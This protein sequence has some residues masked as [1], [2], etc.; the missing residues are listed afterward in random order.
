MNR[1]PALADSLFRD[2]ALSRNALLLAGLVGTIAVTLIGLRH[3]RAFWLLLLFVPL[4]VVA[5]ID[6][7]Q[8][9][10]SLRRNY[11]VSARFRWFFEWLRPFLRSYIVESDLDGRPFSHDERALVYA[12]AKGDVSTHPF[13][14]EL[15]VYSEEYEW[16]AHS[17][18]PSRHAEKYTRVSV[19]TDQCSRP[20]SAARLNISAMSFGALGSNAI[21]A[22]N[23]GARIGGFYHDTGEGGLS[24]YHLKHGGDVV[25]ELGSGYFGC[26]DA[27]GNFDPAHFRDKATNDAVV[28]TEIKLS[29]GAKPGHGGLLP[30]PKV[31]A[32]I[33]RIRDI[34]E[35]EDCLSPPFHTAFSTPRELLAFAAQMR[36]LS[37]GKPV[38]IKLCV[39][40]PHELFAVVKAMI[41]TEILV[42]FIVIDGAEGGT[43]AAPTELSDRV[44][45]PLREGLILARNAL[46]GT[47]LK[48]KVRLAASGKVNSGA[49]IAMNAALGADWCNA[50]R[51]FMF[52]LG[53]VQSMRCHTDTCPT[54]VATQSPA[55]QRALV[56][57]EKA[58]RVARFQRAT[59]DA[60]HDIVV[61]AGLNSPDEFT[62]D[63]LRQ[64]IN[65]AEMRS[66]D[67]IYPF[68]QPGELL[69]GARDPR[70]ANWWNAAD[71]A[72]F[73][74]RA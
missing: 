49:A 4:L 26:R 32:E 36:D 66:I 58:E 51:S 5:L 74:R 37:G 70:L 72:S 12:R 39:G 6:L 38:G 10:H 9:H 63:G 11:P 73:A 21:E 69:D 41:E 31:T 59:L 7:L 29:Q 53:C 23:L 65:A 15:D 47:N 1:R 46:V 42:D 64:R 40:Y 17:I 24:P 14:T 60:L 48:N 8:T 67:E 61:A 55:R 44:G 19:G 28:M 30:G 3:P 45:M 57:P 62:P 25:W 2:H 56:V 35:G 13:G 52:S 43:G 27:S 16:L 22:L 20:Y 54:G 71:P 34:P 18:A 50:A 68:V 33:A